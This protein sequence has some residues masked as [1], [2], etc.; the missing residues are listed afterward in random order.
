MDR[1]K[2]VFGNGWR[3]RFESVVERVHVYGLC[4]L[5]SKMNRTLAAKS[6]ERHVGMGVWEAKFRASEWVGGEREAKDAHRSRSG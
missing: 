4:K 1:I 5:V 2:H 3:G 6:V